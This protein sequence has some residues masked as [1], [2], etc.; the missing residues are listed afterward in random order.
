[1]K[2]KRRC[3]KIQKMWQ[4]LLAF[5][6]CAS[7]HY[8]CSLL[9]LKTNS[10]FF[11]NAVTGDILRSELKMDEFVL[12]RPGNLDTFDSLAAHYLG[13]AD[14][15]WLIAKFN[16]QDQVLP[17]K[18][19]IVPFKT[20][21]L[22]GL[23]EESYQTVPILVY[24]QFSNDHSDK[25]TIKT[26]NF[27]EQMLYLKENGFKVIGLDQLLDFMEFKSPLPEKAIVITIDDGW[28]STYEIAY[29]I[30]KKFGFPATLFVYTDFIEGDQA[31][32]WS[33]LKEMAENGFDIQS[34][35]HSYQSLTMIRENE[36]FKNYFDFLVQEIEASKMAIRHHLNRDC[37]YL[38]Y[39]YGET[40]PLVI[41]L[42]KKLGY[43][44]A[45]T[46]NRGNTPFFENPYNIGRSIIY[47][48]FDMNEFIKKI[49]YKE[50]FS[51][52]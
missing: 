13:D 49:S 27:Y 21:Y 11:Q 46:I 35:T 34:H 12:V 18:S 32:N 52:K 28:L 30:L 38:A 10:D 3:I 43:R 8:G 25:L 51:L 36:S 7:G 20:I 9:P 6:I 50:T 39:P 41:S 4:L 44:A 17:G 33:Q 23:T 45:F 16:R 26:E 22:G 19:L 37:R 42:V 2:S 31:M 47:G 48:D 1:M 40:N 24:H 5:F 14:K 29:P 15:G